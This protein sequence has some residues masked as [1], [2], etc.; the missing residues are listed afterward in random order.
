MPTA[1][2][3]LPIRSWKMDGFCT[4]SM[5]AGPNFQNLIFLEKKNCTHAKTCSW[6]SNGLKYVSRLCGIKPFHHFVGCDRNQ[7]VKSEHAHFYAFLPAKKCTWKCK[8]VKFSLGSRTSS[9]GSACVAQRSK[10]EPG[11]SQPTHWESLFKI[12]VLQ[13][14]SE[15]LQ[16][17]WRRQGEKCCRTHFRSHFFV[18][19]FYQNWCAARLG[20][21]HRQLCYSLFWCEPRRASYGAEKSKMCEK[22]HFFENIT[23]AIVQ[24]GQFCGW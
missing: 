10:I 21:V 23:Y 22:C 24:F 16:G 1:V 4:A 5:L 17:V 11:V 14:Q 9:W 8:K 6:H 20:R 12:L 13:M 3:I 18:S 7:Y 19:E 2:F 15:A